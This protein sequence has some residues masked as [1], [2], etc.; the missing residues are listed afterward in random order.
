MAKRFFDSKVFDKEWFQLLPL[1]LK[2][3]WFYILANC[4]EA[5]V[6]AVNRRQ[7]DFQINTELP[8]DTILE[9]FDGQIALIGA[10][11]W[12]VVDFVKFQYGTLSDDCRPHK[13]AIESLKKHGLVRKVSDTYQIGIRKDKVQ[14]QDKDKVQDNTSFDIFWEAY[15]RKIA[16]GAARD[17]WKK[18]KPTAELSEAIVL[19]IGEQAQSEQWRR[20]GGKF[21]PY[22]STWLNQSRWEDE[23][24]DA[25]PNPLAVRP[26]S[27]EACRALE[28]D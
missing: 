24:G 1:R 17:A 20:D 5:G 4:D 8:W 6:W 18:I 9:Q 3:F 13:K 16:K 19:A 25:K 12:W 27:D 7:A 23:P 10:G 2:C 21:I 11:K 15:P 28:E 26:L 14:V 22:P